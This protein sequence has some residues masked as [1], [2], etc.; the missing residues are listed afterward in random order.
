MIQSVYDHDYIDPKKI[1]ETQRKMSEAKSKSNLEGKI[2][3]Y[4]YGK[5][6][7]VEKKGAKIDFL[8]IENRQEKSK[9][10][11]E[12]VGDTK[13]SCCCAT[14]QI[15]SSC[16]NNGDKRLFKSQSTPSGRERQYPDETVKNLSAKFVRKVI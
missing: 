10:K 1:T 16:H 2:S 11:A 7:R 3:I 12:V 13:V 6:L 14:K 9:V 8:S 5:C 4:D 15:M